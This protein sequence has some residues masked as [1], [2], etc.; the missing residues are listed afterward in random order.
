MSI[1][2]VHT[3]MSVSFHTCRYMFTSCI[4]A[5]PQLR[6]P[7]MSNV[8]D[9]SLANLYGRQIIEELD[10]LVKSGGFRLPI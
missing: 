6:K 9:F 3:Y 4:H 10:V 8:V 5:C 2:Y 1:L 7:D